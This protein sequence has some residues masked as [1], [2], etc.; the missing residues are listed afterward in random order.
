[1]AIKDNIITYSE[2]IAENISKS[3]EYSE[4]IADNCKL[5]GIYSRTT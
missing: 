3:I 1:M 4:Y 5:C 2:Y